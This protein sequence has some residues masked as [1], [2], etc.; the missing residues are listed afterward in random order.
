MPVTTT[1]APTA[2]DA[3]YARQSF[4]ILFFTPTPEVRAAALPLL[5]RFHAKLNAVPWLPHDWL[6]QCEALGKG[7]PPDYMWRLAS[8]SRGAVPNWLNTDAR[9]RAWQ[10][11]V[12]A[13]SAIMRPLL[14]GDLQVATAVVAASEANVA[15]WDNIYKADEYLANLPA[16]VVNASADAVVGAVRT[17][18]A[19]LFGNK[20]T[21]LL[22]GGAVVLVGAV[23]YMKARK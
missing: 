12:D 6:V 10:A 17:N 8:P 19:S 23:I 20:S 4:G 14:A 22:L 2:D 13:E 15:L 1:S 5:R 3:T 16:N 21:L 11:A 9:K 7:Y 18:L